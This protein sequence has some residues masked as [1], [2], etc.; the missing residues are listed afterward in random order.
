MKRTI[1]SAAQSGFKI[2]VL[3]MC[4]LFLG[5]FLT[6]T[7]DNGHLQW[8]LLLPGSV[9][10]IF[11]VFAIS[12]KTVQMDERAL[13]V[14][15]FRRVTVIPLEKIESVTERIGLKDRLVTIRF[16][17]DTPVGRSICFS[18]TTRLDYKPHPIVSELQS[19]ANNT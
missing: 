11:L 17:K 8:Q 3:V 19:H 5:F 18:P 6:S 1:S 12:R 13:Y 4:V 16:R 10:G 14:S 7:L 15:T 9:P 2:L